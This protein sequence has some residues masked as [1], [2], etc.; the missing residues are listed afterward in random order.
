MPRKRHLKVPYT[1]PKSAPPWS[2]QGKKHTKTFR[3]LE[4]D[5]VTST[6]NSTRTLPSTPGR[7]NSRP[8]E[9]GLGHPEKL[10]E[11]DQSPVSSPT[12]SSLDFNV[13][14]PSVQTIDSPHQT[15][16]SPASDLMGNSTLEYLRTMNNQGTDPLNSDDP[17]LDPEESDQ[18][19]A[20]DN[21][22]KSESEISPGEKPKISP[23]RTRTGTIYHPG[24]TGTTFV[25][26]NNQGKTLPNQTTIPMKSITT[27]QDQEEVN[28]RSESETEAS[29]N[30]QLLFDYLTR[31]V[32]F[33][34]EIN[35]FYWNQFGHY[36]KEAIDSL[37]QNFTM[38]KKEHERFGQLIQVIGQEIT[39]EEDFFDAL[40][41]VN[42]S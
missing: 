39:N 35:E 40:D 24:V 4:P 34:Y 16:S 5:P 31:A 13:S 11:T 37:E 23:R 12:N 36:I 41:D 20:T 29:L 42:G 28:E 6:P 3:R 9:Q 30:Y 10:F 27:I 8:N 25:Q 7:P 17:R 38:L 21:L 26:P 22:T 14:R 32:S 19:S 18:N 1:H 2:R 15:N 33:R